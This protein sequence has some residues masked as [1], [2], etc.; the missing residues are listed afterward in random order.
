MITIIKRLSETFFRSIGIAGMLVVCLAIIPVEAAIT[1]QN[2]K[3]RE[4]SV[5]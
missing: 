4:N 2:I 5:A 1:P 3:T